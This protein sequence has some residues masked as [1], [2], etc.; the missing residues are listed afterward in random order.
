MFTLVTKFVKRIYKVLIVIA[1]TIV[2]FFVYNRYLIDYSLSNLSTTLD[3]LNDVKTREGAKQLSGMLDYSLLKEV[4]SV[5]LESANL[6][7]IAFVKDILSEPE[8]MSQL[9]EA[10]LALKELVEQ[11]EKKR[12]P[13]LVFLDR[14]SKAIFPGTKKASDA[15]LE[16]RIK[17]LKSKISIT[18]DDIQAQEIYYELASAYVQLSKYQEAK[19]A[20][21]K[22]VELAP[23]SKLAQRAKFNL[24]WNEKSQ[25]N[26]DEA[27]RQFEQIAETSS[28]NNSAVFSKYQVAE[29]SRKKGDYE[30]AAQ[31]YKEISAEQQDKE[32]SK[33]ATFKAGYTYLYDLKDYARAK[34]VLD[35][36]GGL[37]EGSSVAEHIEK[38][39]SSVMAIQYRKEG[40]QLLSQGYDSSSPQIYKEALKSF[41]KALEITPEDGLCYTGKAL[42]LL[43]LKDSSGGLE[44]ARKAVMFSPNDEAASINLGYICLQLGLTNEAIRE[45]KRLISVNPLTARGYYNLGYA[46]VVSGRMKEAS[47]AFEQS[48][49]INPKSHVA[50]NNQG[51]CLWQLGRY[52]EA[53]E[54]FE[55]AIQLKP[56]FTDALFNLGMVYKA[57][58]RNEEAKVKFEV[59]LDKDPAFPG[60]KDY[61]KKVEEA[62]GK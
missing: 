59:I 51:W 55:K 58:G 48:T 42:A 60:A 6:S 32:L 57:I 1:I 39:A 29:V 18:E 23:E 25:G 21:V 36:A 22:V 37:L 49:K 28:E 61:L 7:K 9:E 40:F 53:I 20:Y 19:E 33:V 43:W 5:E 8:N 38:T 54:A 44:A 46:Y 11:K 56:N 47:A 45:Y 17:A 2:F 50:F 24:A 13:I 62:L 3:R 16:S 4:S 27:I 15:R 26:F 52:P 14:V 34:E 31:I 35:E 41:D 30:K 12:S 10:R